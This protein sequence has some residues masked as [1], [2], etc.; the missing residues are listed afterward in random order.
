MCL[1]IF[2]LPW[3]RMAH[4]RTYHG[5]T[6]LINYNYRCAKLFKKVS[7]T[8]NIIMAQCMWHEN[9]NWKLD[10]IYRPLSFSRLQKSHRRFSH[11]QA[12]NT[13]FPLTGYTRPPPLLDYGQPPLPPPPCWAM[14]SIPPGWA[15]A[16]CSFSPLWWNIDWFASNQ[17][18]LSY[19]CLRTLINNTLGVNMNIDHDTL[20]VKL[21]NL[22][23]EEEAR[24]Q[25]PRV[26]ITPTVQCADRTTR[27]SHYVSVRQDMFPQRS[28][29]KQ[30]TIFFFFRYQ[31]ARLWIRY[32]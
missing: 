26:L 6:F 5:L 1:V 9:K 28:C 27:S 13:C 10:L 24:Y 12:E 17:T 15:I 31:H 18:H 32:V 16:N 29:L 20:R 7:G 4:G 14:V 3:S 30:N 22:N 11:D 2:L 21:S 8:T 23:E 25:V 19:S